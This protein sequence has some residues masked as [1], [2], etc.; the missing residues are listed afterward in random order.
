[1]LFIIM[2]GLHKVRDNYDNLHDTM[3]TYQKYVDIKT[4]KVVSKNIIITD[5]VI[6]RFRGCVL[7]AN[8]DEVI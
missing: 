5:I 3:M 8:T 6:D 1:M 2:I 7:I 4:T